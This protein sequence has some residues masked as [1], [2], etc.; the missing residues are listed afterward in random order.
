MPELPEV[1]TTATGLNKEIGG[2]KITEVWTDYNSTFHA[3]KNNIKNPAFFRRFKKEILGAKV[4]HVG[5]RGKN[6]LIHL[7]NNKTI[8]VHM[9]MT[10]HIMYGDYNRED[11]FNGFIHFIVTFSNKKTMELSDMRKFAKV[12]LVE[13]ECP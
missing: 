4:D 6:V 12:T 2:L 11:P 13:T 9:K 7:D 10:G 8:L 5:R 1:H 3:G